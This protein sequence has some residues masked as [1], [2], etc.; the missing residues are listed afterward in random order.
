MFNFCEVF[1][2]RAMFT[3][4]G[5][6]NTSRRKFKAPWLQTKV[7][8]M[9]DLPKISF[10]EIASVAYKINQIEKQK[11]D[12]SVKFPTGEEASEKNDITDAI[13]CQYVQNTMSKDAGRT[14]PKTTWRFEPAIR[15]LSKHNKNFI[16]KVSSKSR[17]AFL[18]RMIYYFQKKSSYILRNKTTKNISKKVNKI[19]R[20]FLPK[21]ITGE[22]ESWN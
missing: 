1:A 13:N 20:L 12:N 6:A 18:W 2:G 7:Q 5:R 17:R 21:Y 14:F 4:A 10:T 22:L 11:S 3:D 8:K 16:E 9:K 19:N 15:S